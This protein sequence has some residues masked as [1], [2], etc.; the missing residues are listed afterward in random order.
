MSYSSGAMRRLR[1]AVLLVCLF[2]V[3]TAS[4]YGPSGEPGVPVAGGK[5]R[6]VVVGRQIR[7]TGFHAS[8][9]VRV[10]VLQSGAKRVARRMTA[11]A[12]GTF[13]MRM[14][15]TLNRCEPAVVVA[16]GDEGSHAT[17]RLPRLL[18]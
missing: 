6:L 3:P 1:S 7:G 2:V 5:A 12:N 14:T 11:N 4:A 8:E 18:C 13:A 17:Y 9:H 10:S 15:T 16:F